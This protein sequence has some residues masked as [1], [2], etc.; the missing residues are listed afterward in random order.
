MQDWLN[1]TEN[2][3]A[4][5]GDVCALTVGYSSKERVFKLGHPIFNEESGYLLTKHAKRFTSLSPEQ[6]SALS[7]D[8]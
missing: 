7:E 3:F 2:G 1:S 6:L 5:H 8:S 4:G